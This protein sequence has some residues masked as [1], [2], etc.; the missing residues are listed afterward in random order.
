ML[1][2]LGTVITAALMVFVVAA[3]TA[4]L[5]ISRGAKLPLQSSAGSGSGSPAR[6]RLPAGSRSRNHF[7]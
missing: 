6:P 3:L 1:D 5:D 2:F 7:R 4:Y